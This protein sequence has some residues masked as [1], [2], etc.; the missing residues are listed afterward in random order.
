MTYSLPSVAVTKYHKLGGLKQSKF[1]LLN[2]YEGQKSTIKMSVGLV[3]SGSSEGEIDSLAVSYLLVV[4]SKPLVFFDILLQSLS[5][6]NVL[7]LHMAL[8]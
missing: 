4:A 3:P 1:I 2:S 7:P 8:L 5:S 6:C